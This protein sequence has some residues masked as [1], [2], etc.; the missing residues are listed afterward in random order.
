MYSSVAR[1]LTEP[2]YH[3]QCPMPTRVAAVIFSF[4]AVS[5]LILL[6]LRPLDKHTPLSMKGTQMPNQTLS[7]IGRATYRYCIR[8]CEAVNY[9]K[10][11]HQR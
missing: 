5:Q 2:L 1:L 7:S 4:I 9:R 8:A 3:R 10:L 6:T 11:L